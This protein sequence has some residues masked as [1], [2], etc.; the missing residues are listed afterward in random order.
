MGRA[1]HACRRIGEQDGGA[2]RRQH[3]DGQ[4][5]GPRDDAV[6]A[7]QV[8][9]GNR[10]LDDDGR[11][12]MDLMQGHQVVRGQ[13]SCDAAAV[14]A[15]QRL[16]VARAEAAVEAGVDAGRDTAGAREEPVGDSRQSRQ[17]VGSD[18]REHRRLPCSSAPCL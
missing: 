7:R 16:V 10:V 3:A 18:R 12:A 4:S 14:L 2:V 6:G 5:S 1:D 13:V 11:G 8:G 9:V 17:A 15:H